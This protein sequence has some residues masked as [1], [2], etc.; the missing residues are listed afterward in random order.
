MEGAKEFLT[1]KTLLLLLAP[2]FFS[3]SLPSLLPSGK[4][5]GALRPP[6]RR[7]VGAVNIATTSIEYVSE[8][9]TRTRTE[10]RAEPRR[11][12]PTRQRVGAFQRF[13][14]L[15][16]C[17]AN[18]DVD[19]CLVF[20][21]LVTPLLWD[22]DDGGGSEVAQVH[23]AAASP[24]LCIDL[25]G[26]VRGRVPRSLVLDVVRGIR[27]WALAEAQGGFEGPKGRRVGFHQ[28]LQRP[29]LDVE[30]LHDRSQRRGRE[31]PVRRG[32][33]HLDDQ[34]ARLGRPHPERHLPEELHGPRTHRDEPEPHA[35]LDGV[36][37]DGVRQA[38][39]GAHRHGV[40]PLP[41]VVHQIVGRQVR[42]AR[43]RP[44]HELLEDDCLGG[45]RHQ[46]LRPLPEPRRAGGARVPLPDG[47]VVPFPRLG[48][49]QRRERQVQSGFPVSPPPLPA[50][51]ARVRTA[52]PWP[53]RARSRPGATASCSP[54][55]PA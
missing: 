15:M 20:C 14:V 53:S 27:T 12:G 7:T 17:N 34:V 37:L 16:Q 10:G 3:P 21:R 40:P 41:Q 13:P 50:R 6:P 29:N 1:P 26:G 46:P 36:H 11:A 42:P 44:L 2:S 55:T 52:G 18:V 31:G 35:A 23:Q 28:P 8:L 24:G 33:R 25:G 51:P 32:P 9:A 49:G 22:R 30:G 38:E 5:A 39:F 48:V 45:H 43:P 47:D 19:E 54:G 4:S